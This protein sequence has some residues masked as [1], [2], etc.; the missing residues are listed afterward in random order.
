MKNSVFSKMI[1]FFSCVLFLS[2]AVIVLYSGQY[3]NEKAR[4]ALE[5]DSIRAI[6]AANNYVNEKYLSA[7]RM[8][9][10]LYK[11]KYYQIIPSYM[12]SP[13]SDVNAR[14]NFSS[15]LD[16]FLQY[17]FSS[18]LDISNIALEI[19]RDQSVYLLLKEAD[20]DRKI[21]AELR[22]LISQYQ[23]TMKPYGA[24][25]LPAYTS[26]VSP[27]RGTT[28][29]ILCPVKQ[30]D[31]LSDLG[32]IL[33]VFSTQD[34]ESNLPSSFEDSAN[35]V[36]YMVGKDGVILYDS[37]GDKTGT[38]YPDFAELETME[39]QYK[40][41][42]SGTYYVGVEYDS[43]LGVYFVSHQS[44]G[45]VY[46]S[47]YPQKTVIYVGIFLLSAISI[48]S[49][50]LFSRKYSRRI[51][52]I[53]AAIHKI[54]SGNLDVR[55]PCSAQNDELSL[56]SGNLND[57][58]SMLQDYIQRV[59]VKQIEA[60]SNELLRKDAEL[61]QKAAE[62][63]A[64]QT[65]INPH[66]LYNTLEAIRMRALSEGNRDVAQMTYLLSTLFRQTLKTGFVC[67]IPE[68][69]DTCRLYLEL[70]TYRYQDRIQTS[71]QVEEDLEACG[72]IRHILQPI[73]ENSMRHGFRPESKE[74]RIE[75][76]IFRREEDVILMVKD[77][78]R[79]IPPER[80]DFLRQQLDA[81]SPQAQRIGLANVHQRI[82]GIFGEGYGVT[83]ESDLDQGTAVSIRIPNMTIKEMK[84]YVQRFDR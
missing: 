64:L 53:C 29:P 1:L 24:T 55:I 75:I 15:T 66:F 18:D 79:G 10:S 11:T 36:L 9:A 76:S 37:S 74:N 35:S 31:M 3:L 17:H 70:S 42:D 4:S 16:E 8:I 47:L 81:P 68:E 69:V 12:G 5:N 13:S 67:S 50:F 30:M 78:G 57:M 82:V 63:Y 7:Q 49:I 77:N 65:Q 38:A 6:N 84:E 46:M 62:L 28:L 80:L 43:E 45:V 33:V 34:M 14:Q 25:I 22:A 83:L 59:Y 2:F 40:E 72:V 58:C 73:V 21:E 61:K 71:I 52:A 20:K 23:P 41:M 60:Q 54:R 51:A 39:N 26:A 56:I 48:C 27:Y 44:L 32:C 19:Y